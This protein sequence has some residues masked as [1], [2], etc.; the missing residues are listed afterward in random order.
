MFITGVS[1]ITLDDVTSG[2]NIGSNFTTDPQFNGIVCFFLSLW[3][4]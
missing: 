2:F 1:P 3:K 4:N